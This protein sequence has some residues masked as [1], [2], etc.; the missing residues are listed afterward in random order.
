MIII[1][2]AR[3]ASGKRKLGELHK[4]L[5]ELM[6]DAYLSNIEAESGFEGRAA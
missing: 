1:K 5:N 6:H 4:Y 2:I 3:R